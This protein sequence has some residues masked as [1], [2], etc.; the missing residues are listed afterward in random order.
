MITKM[1][2]Y[3]ENLTKFNSKVQSR[4]RRMNMPH[5]CALILL[6]LLQG[7]E[8]ANNMSHNELNP[9]ALQ[10]DSPSTKVPTPV[11]IP[12]FQ[13]GMPVLRPRSEKS[14]SGTDGPSLK[15]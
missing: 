3:T 13:P 6:L 8:C 11:D 15:H 14:E 2:I 9:T 7:D 1:I 10:Q 5:M 12:Q 4:D